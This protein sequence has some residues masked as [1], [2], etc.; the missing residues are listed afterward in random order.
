MLPSSTRDTV[1]G[2]VAE[3]LSGLDDL[4]DVAVVLAAAATPERSDARPRP[5]ARQTVLTL[6]TAA[7]PL[8]TGLAGLSGRG[9]FRR[10]MRTLA[11]CDRYA[12]GL[13]RLATQAPGSPE[14]ARLA[15]TRGG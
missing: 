3:F 5:Q 7:R 14:P 9:G 1:S 8:T 10:T 2:H 12:R 6:R 4:L 11:A 13:A 15:L